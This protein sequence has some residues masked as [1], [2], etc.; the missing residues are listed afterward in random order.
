M[1]FDGAALTACIVLQAAPHGFESVID[2][3]AKIPVRDFQLQVLNDSSLSN[4]RHGAAQAGLP[5]YD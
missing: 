5:S 4:L 3:L 1:G 2:G